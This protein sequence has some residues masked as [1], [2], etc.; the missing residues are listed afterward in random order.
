MFKHGFSDE[1]PIEEIVESFLDIKIRDKPLKKVLVK[2]ASKYDKRYKNLQPTYA[3]FSSQSLRVKFEYL[4][5]RVIGLYELGDIETTSRKKF[6]WELTSALRTVRM[7]KV[8]DLKHTLPKNSKIEPNTDVTKTLSVGEK[9]EVALYE[10]R[11]GTLNIN[12]YAY[13]EKDDL[14]IDYWKLSDKREDEYFITVKKENLE[15]LCKKLETE[16]NNKELLLNELLNEFSGVNCFE[17]VKSFLTLNNIM[18]EFNERYDE[19]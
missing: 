16:N 3:Q 15:T 14:V 1:L 5:S 6:F 7:S 11:N 18:F 9:L 17:K 10:Y 12:S 2:M 4:L 13:F 19:R 8:S